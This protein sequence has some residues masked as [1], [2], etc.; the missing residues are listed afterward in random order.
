MRRSRADTMLVER[1]LATTADEA[2]R[3][4]LAGRARAGTARIKSPGELL[5]ADAELS[6]TEQARYVSR[7][8]D[9]L[10][11]ALDHFAISPNGRVCL[12]AGA[13]TGGFTDCLLQRGAA[14]VY[15]VDV[16]YGQLDWRL[17]GDA[18]VV[19]LERTNVRE[20]DAESLAPRP[21]LVVADLAFIGLR[22]VLPVLRS[23]LQGEGEMVLLVKP[24]FELPREDVRGGVVT[25]AVLHRRAV[26]LVEEAARSRGF[27]LIGDVE[28]PLKGP[29]GN[30]EFFVALRS[31][32][33][34]NSTGC[35]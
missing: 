17:R 18:R 2:A 34:A 10:A 28:S 5:S 21:D 14:R 33:Q 24:Q 9:K 32:A 6:L 26:D 13:S 3:L 19:V 1:G 25:D 22:T 15:A 20:L 31:G 7:G 11:A 8:G 30:R 29:K 16:G 23:F 35:K 27:D 4:I 12:D